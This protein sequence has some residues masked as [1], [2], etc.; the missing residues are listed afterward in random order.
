MA[1]ANHGGVMN[2]T[3]AAYIFTLACF[4]FCFWLFLV[5]IAD[6]QA[7]REEHARI[8]HPAPVAGV[9]VVTK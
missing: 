9:R 1:L 2:R 7:E 5:G 8:H 3:I 6:L 4:G